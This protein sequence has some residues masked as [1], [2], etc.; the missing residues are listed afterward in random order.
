[1]SVSIEPGGVRVGDDFVPIPEW[2]TAEIVKRHPGGAVTPCVK[3][4]SDGANYQDGRTR[5]AVCFPG[6]VRQLVSEL[7]ANKAR[8]DWER[9]RMKTLAEE[10]V[11]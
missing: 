4:R 8:H 7:V 11:G 5:G 2:M 3:L 1:M 10:G 6:N 9:D